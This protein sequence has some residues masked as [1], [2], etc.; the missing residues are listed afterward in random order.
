MLKSR[1]Q[2]AVYLGFFAIIVTALVLLIHKIRKRANK[3][4]HFKRVVIQKLQVIGIRQNRKE[5]A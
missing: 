1:N 4:C 3:C 2:T 5:N